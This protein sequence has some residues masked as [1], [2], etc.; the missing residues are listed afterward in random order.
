MIIGLAST[1]YR[2]GRRR[3]RAFIDFVIAAGSVQLSTDGRV[4]RIHLIRH[5][6]ARELGA[7]A[8]PRAGPAARAQPLEMSP[9]SRSQGVARVPE[10]DRRHAGDA[11][12][13]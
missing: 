1:I 2:A 13:P 8:N 11:K 12:M 9:S 6:R 3:A 10:L 5:D 7:L 4:I